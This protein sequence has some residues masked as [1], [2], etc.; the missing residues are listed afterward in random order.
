MKLAFSSSSPWVRRVLVVAAELGLD[1]RIEPVE[2]GHRDEAGGY[3]AVNPLLKV[4]A[5][6]LDD[7]EVLIDSTAISEY[8]DMRHDGPKLFPPVGETR[9]RRM[10]IQMLV[11]GMQEAATVCV[12]ESVR[13][14]EALRWPAF[15]EKYESKVRRGLDRLEEHAD[16]PDGRLDYTTISTGVLCGFLDFRFS[17]TNWRDGHPK[18]AAWYAVF[19]ERASMKASEF[20]LS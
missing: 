7:G 18:L 19:A 5:L 3:A 4:P 8:L 9:V 12:G 2:M 16:R 6:I 10:Q 14:P 1:D 15:Y 17:G 20:R 13:R 11:N